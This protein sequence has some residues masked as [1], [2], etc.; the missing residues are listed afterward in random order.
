[1]KYTYQQLKA[2]ARDQRINPDDFSDVYNDYQ[3]SKDRELVKSLDKR[4]GK[5]AMMGDFLDSDVQEY[6]TVQYLQLDDWFGEGERDEN[7][8]EPPFIRDGDEY[9]KAILT[10]RYDDYVNGA[11]VICVAKNRDTEFEPVPFVLD[12]TYNSDPEKIYEKMHRYHSKE[13]IAGFTSIRYFSDDDS[14]SGVPIIKKGG[15]DILPR[16]V[17]GYSNEISDKLVDDLVQG[18]QYGDTTLSNKAKCYVLAE[19][20]SQSEQMLKFFEEEYRG[21]S[22][23]MNRMMHDVE[24]LDRYFAGAID[25]ARKKDPSLPEHT[26]AWG[27]KDEVAKQI[28]AM[29]IY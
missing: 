23:S 20:K 22:A 24:C 13:E 3:R 10:S 4:F 8:G 14:V 29:W 19:L 2:D 15:I 21:N 18:V 5:T 6:V 26:Y 9:G 17:V 28:L 7:N 27:N 16:F 1:M 11:D 12:L 25:V